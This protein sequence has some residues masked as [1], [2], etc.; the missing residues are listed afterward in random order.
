MRIC[1]FTPSFL[2]ELGG[3]EIVIDRLARQ[4][5]DMG[6]E[7]VV[8]AQKPRHINFTADDRSDYAENTEKDLIKKNSACSAVSAVRMPLDVPYDVVYYPRPRSAV[9]LL[10]SVK[11]LL[12]NEHQRHRF[13]I[14]HAHMAY[15]TGF[16]AAKLKHRL[17]IPVVITSHKG[18]IVPESRYRQRFITRRRLCW[19]MKNADAVTGVSEKLK[20]II[21]ELTQGQ[22]K[23][24]TIS[25]GVDMPDDSPGA[26]PEACR[27]LAD[28]P[29]MLTLGRLHQYKGLDVL[30]DAMAILKKQDVTIP[31]LVIAGEGKELDNLQKQVQKLNLDSLVFFTGAVFG[32]QKHWLLRNCEFF[33]QPSRAEGMPLT[34]LEAFAYGKPVIGTKISGIEELVTPGKTGYLVESDDSRSL[35]G[36][37]LEASTNSAIGKM[38]AEARR[39]ASTRTWPVIAAKYID[40][41]SGLR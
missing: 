41:F 27:S 37:I 4:F 32:L 26:M 21:D 5:K 24:L 20:D 36:A 25:N 18:D 15:P 39:F 6:H 3:M 9:W 16:I 17:N 19:A 22:A 40:L 23:S 7:A 1:L 10:G 8:I 31:C 29:F 30:L 12:L 28:R 13:D 2:P 11:R 34:V 35:A 14:I 38:G 33:L